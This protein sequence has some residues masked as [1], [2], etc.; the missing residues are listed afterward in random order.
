MRLQL[1]LAPSA[2]GSQRLEPLTLRKTLGKIGVQFG[3]NFAAPSLGLEHS[4]NRNE[5]SLNA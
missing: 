2:I 5:L 4:R 1:Q 3:G